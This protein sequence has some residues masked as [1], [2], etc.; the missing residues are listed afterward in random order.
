MH[1]IKG[2]SSFFDFEKLVELTYHAED[3]LNQLREGEPAVKR[4]NASL[5]SQLEHT[6]RAFFGYGRANRSDFNLLDLYRTARRPTPGAGIVCTN[7]NDRFDR[8]RCAAGHD[9]SDPM[10]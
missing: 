5:N 8:V 1:T 2:A 4:L 3:L 9:L 10:S 6:T 7:L